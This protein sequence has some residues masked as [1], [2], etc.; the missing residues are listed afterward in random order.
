MGLNI[1]G[2]VLSLSNS[3]TRRQAFNDIKNI[4]ESSLA[5]IKY[6]YIFMTVYACPLPYKF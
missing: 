2:L 3:L 4:I 6:F 5:E 1:V